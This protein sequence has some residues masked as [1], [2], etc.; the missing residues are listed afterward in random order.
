MKN[1]YILANI[2]EGSQDL[3]YI[4]QFAPN[5]LFN[6]VPFLTVQ[7]PE[8]TQNGYSATKLIEKLKNSEY[9]VEGITYPGTKVIEFMKLF[10]SEDT[11]VFMK[12]SQTRE[13][14]WSSAVPIIMYMYKLQHNIKYSE[15]DRQDKWLKVLLG[16]KLEWLVD[17]E[18]TMPTRSCSELQDLQLKSLTTASTG[19]VRSVTS[20]IIAKR[21][22]DFEFDQLPRMARFML[23]Q[24]W[25]YSLAARTSAMITDPKNWDEFSAP[26][27]SSSLITPEAKIA[28]FKTTKPQPTTSSGELP[29]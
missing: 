23:V 10:Y 7:Y 2:S 13:P 14:N 24:T 8:K 25:I 29:W 9:T 11:K 3:K 21:T 1:A 16:K 4:A 15:W 26:I 5:S 28:N 27:S 12:A 22:G 6:L 19:T 20:H 18:F 17:P